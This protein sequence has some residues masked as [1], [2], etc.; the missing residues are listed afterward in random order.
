[1]AVYHRAIDINPKSAWS[2]YNLAEVLEKQG[3]LE[4]SISAYRRAIDINP[5]YPIFHQKLE[6]VLAKQRS[7]A[8]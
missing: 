5:G 2:Y 3:D 4:E 6:S 1:M 7:Q 8:E